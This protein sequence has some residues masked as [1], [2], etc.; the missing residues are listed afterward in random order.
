MLLRITLF[1][2]LL[3]NADP[4][5]EIQPYSLNAPEHFSIF[6]F[7]EIVSLVALLFVFFSVFVL[8]LNYNLKY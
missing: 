7:L 1:E 5:I 4:T 6:A 8:L 3:N 2:I